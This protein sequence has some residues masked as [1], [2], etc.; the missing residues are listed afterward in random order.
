[1]NSKVDSLVVSTSLL[2]PHPE[3]KN[4]KYQIEI[5]YKTSIPKNIESWQVFKDDKGLQLFLEN[6]KTTHEDQPNER[7]Q[8]DLH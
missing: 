1:M 7:N 3:F 4:K 6:V 8:E 2:L 5:M